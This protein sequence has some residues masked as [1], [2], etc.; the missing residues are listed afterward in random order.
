MKPVL[1]DTS[2]I[3]AAFD[4]RAEQHE[5]TKSA[6]EA[7]AERP[8]ISCQA[9]VTE[10]CFLFQSRK[11]FGARRDLLDNVV[12]GRLKLV[13]PVVASVNALMD[14]YERVPM[15]FAD[16]CLVNLADQLDT[17]DVLTLDND[18]RIYRWRRLR[19]FQ[20]WPEA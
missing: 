18:F 11:L 8:L 6:F 1:V 2:A 16:G 17:D 12:A 9:V 10:A 13:D 14:R 4:R 3:V 19:R 5:A 20:I 15:Q 7:I